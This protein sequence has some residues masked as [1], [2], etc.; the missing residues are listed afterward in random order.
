MCLSY[1]RTRSCVGVKL[2]FSLVGPKPSKSYGDQAFSI[3]ATTL[4]NNLPI[5]LRIITN[6]DQHFF[7]KKTLSLTFYIK[8]YI[9][10]YLV[11]V[12]VIGC[13]CRSYCTM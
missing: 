12:F 4:G 13:F 10:D 3:Y 6:F 5:H 8:C 9:V 2:I 11:L 1:I 7:L